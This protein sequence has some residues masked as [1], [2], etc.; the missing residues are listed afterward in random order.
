MKETEMQVAIYA[1]V[2]SERQC[3]A[4]TIGSQVAALKERVLADGFSLMEESCFL[5]DGYPGSTLLRHALERL[6]DMA[7]A[8]GVDRL[9][10][11]SPDR[12]ARNYAYQVLLLE[13]F[14]HDG[15]E[16]VFLN[17]TPGTSPEEKLLL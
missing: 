17:H 12:L 14:Q 5:D 8:G 11:H 16:T 9:Y 13:E 4:G 7:V 10:V 15:V 1:R 2:S 3:Q 6:R